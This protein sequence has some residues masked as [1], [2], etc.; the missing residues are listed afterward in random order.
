MA[1]SDE[2]TILL[3]AGRRRLYPSIRDP[4]WLVLRRRR[5]IF[6]IW[7]NK[8]PM[9]HPAVLDVG[10]RIQP[11]RELVNQPRRY[12]AIDLRANNLIS[13][14]ASAEQMPFRDGIFDLVICTQMIEYTP[15]PLMVIRE[16][17]RVLRPGGVLLL[18]APTI[19]PRDSEH[20]R[21]RF[22]PPALADLL[23]G[24][25]EVEIVPETS[26]AAGFFRTIAVGCNAA[27]HR[28]LLK[29]I[30]SVVLFPAVN[31]IGAMLNRSQGQQ[32]GSFTVNYSVRA[33]K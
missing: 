14:V 21:W 19:F 12:C 16:I 28:K 25:S 24:F 4:N 1:A 11:Y 6:R 10:G 17:H 22:F 23:R 5:E 7:L 13:A 3:E 33:V 27:V 9:Q 2:L 20:D 30:L 15:H 18:S 32:P 8:L 26:S 31:C 29:A